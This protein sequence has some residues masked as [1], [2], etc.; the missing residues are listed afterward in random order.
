MH[1][2]VETVFC[3]LWTTTVFDFPFASTKYG[4]GT[5][6]FYLHRNCGEQCWWLAARHRSFDISLLNYLLNC[7]LKQPAVPSAF[8]AGHQL[9]DSS[10]VALLIDSVGTTC[11]AF[12]IASGVHAIPLTIALV[13]M[14]SSGNAETLSSDIG[15]IYML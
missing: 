11:I 4:Y 3:Y 14:V 10:K 15:G 12:E 5:V 2:E 1:V 13:L 7:F 6:V 9:D 8:F